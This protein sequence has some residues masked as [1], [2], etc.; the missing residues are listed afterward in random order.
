[1][2]FNIVLAIVVAAAV[3]FSFLISMANIYA[4]SARAKHFKRQSELLG[5]SLKKIDEEI[6]AAKKKL[7]ESLQ[8]NSKN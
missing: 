4:N 8:G 2:D 5:E 7:Q 1:M 3:A 6:E